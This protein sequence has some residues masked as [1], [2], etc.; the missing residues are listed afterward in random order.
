MRVYAG[1]FTGTQADEM[2]SSTIVPGV[3]RR[4]FEAEKNPRI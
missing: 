2:R 3:L 4:C 1:D